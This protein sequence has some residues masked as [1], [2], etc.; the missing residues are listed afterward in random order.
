MGSEVG[1][2][3]AF[4][5][6]VALVVV[7]AAV[8]VGASVGALVFLVVALF[9]AGFLAVTFFGSG[10]VTKKGN[11]STVCYDYIQVGLN[12]RQEKSQVTLQVYTTNIVSADKR[13]SNN[14]YP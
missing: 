5:P 8:L 9:A 2:T 4:L 12:F 13:F 6:L 3:A 14:Y 7:L 1:V 10:S 11:D